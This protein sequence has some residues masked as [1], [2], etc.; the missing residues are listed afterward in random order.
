MTPLICQKYRVAGDSVAGGTTK[1]VPVRPAWLSTVVVN[2]ML[3]DIST[4]NDVAAP[5]AGVTSQLRVGVTPLGV[6]ARGVGANRGPAGVRSMLAT[7]HLDVPRAVVTRTCQKY[8]LVPAR[9]PAGTVNT[10]PGAA[11]VP[12]ATI[13]AAAIV[14]VVATST[15]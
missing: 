11:T 4:S 5:A 14:P 12:V 10:T 15:S 8:V 7:D 3:V 9:A 13:E 6:I 1:E 2:L